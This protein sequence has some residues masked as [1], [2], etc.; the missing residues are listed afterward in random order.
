[1]NISDLSYVWHHWY[2]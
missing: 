2:R 1:M